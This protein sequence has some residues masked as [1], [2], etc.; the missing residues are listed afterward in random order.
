MDGTVASFKSSQDETE[1]YQGGKLKKSSLGF[2]TEK[3]LKV[4][5]NG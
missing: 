5:V 1:K 2:P 3:N 4:F